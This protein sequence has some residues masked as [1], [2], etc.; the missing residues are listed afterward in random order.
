MP[1]P[2]KDYLLKWNL[3]PCNDLELAY[4]AGFF[5]GEGCIQLRGPS[6]TGRQIETIGGVTLSANVVNTSLTILQQFKEN[7]GGGIYGKP[8]DKVAHPFRHDTHYW[9]V[10]GRQAGYFLSLIA[11][12]LRVKR[13][14]A[15]AAISFAETFFND[16]RHM[17]RAGWPLTEQALKLRTV[18]FK[19]FRTAM[20]SARALS[21]EL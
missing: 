21:W 18:S 7:F 17:A 14:Q 10:N 3:P 1:L 4:F 8:L 15:E 5:D 12:H 2:I 9:I 16:W 20:N 11:P 13:L 6:K 19:A